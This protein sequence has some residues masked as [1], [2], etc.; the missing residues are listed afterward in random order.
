MIKIATESDFCY[1][2]CA[3]EWEQQ[4]VVFVNVHDVCV[5]GSST[6]CFCI[7]LVH[8]NIEI[9]S[10]KKKTLKLKNTRFPLK[11]VTTRYEGGE[12]KGRE[13]KGSQKILEESLIERRELASVFLGEVNY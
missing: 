6:S 4:R 8:H 1:G 3:G 7:L 5:D 12:N 11:R 2:S 10:F 13:T 9:N